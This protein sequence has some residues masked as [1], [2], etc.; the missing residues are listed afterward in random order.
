MRLVS[1]S[2]RPDDDPLFV[3]FAANF[4]LEKGSGGLEAIWGLVG[5]YFEF[6]REA[7]CEVVEA[8][9]EVVME[10]LGIPMVARERKG[11]TERFK[12]AFQPQFVFST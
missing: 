2:P 11:T 7:A 4:N 9:V 3:T 12:P 5:R 6:A 8:A 10:I 1:R